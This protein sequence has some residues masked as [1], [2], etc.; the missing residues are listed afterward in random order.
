[1]GSS[2]RSSAKCGRQVSSRYSRGSLTSTSSPMAQA[3]PLTVGKS[4]AFVSR[5]T[6][7]SSCPGNPDRQMP[8]KALLLLPGLLN[9]RRVFEHQ[10]EAISDVADCIVPELW[11]YDTVK[12]MADA[13]LAAAP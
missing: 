7:L 10:I 1:M 13:A 5:R 9:T 11:Q 4:S 3:R 6:A 12:A 8:K 2:R